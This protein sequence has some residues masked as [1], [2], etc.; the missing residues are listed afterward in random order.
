[1]PAVLLE[2]VHRV[3]TKRSS[4]RQGLET[5]KA[6]QSSSSHLDTINQTNIGF[7]TFHCREFEDIL[8]TMAVRDVREH[9]NQG[10]RISI[11]HVRGIG[12][13]ETHA[14][15]VAALFLFT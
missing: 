2:D 7:E 6:C 3:E 15:I 12:E 1:M 14:E 5:G 4:I 10:C 9:V 13:L 11:V 8:N